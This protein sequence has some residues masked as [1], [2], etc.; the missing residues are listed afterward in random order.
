ML[1]RR[2]AVGWT[3]GFQSVPQRRRPFRPRWAYVTVDDRRI[4]IELKTGKAKQDE[5]SRL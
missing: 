4:T 2:A 5:P 1:A 3:S